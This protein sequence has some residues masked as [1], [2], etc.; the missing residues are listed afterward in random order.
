MQFFLNVIVRAK[1]QPLFRLVWNIDSLT[2]FKKL[3]LHYCLFESCEADPQL[4]V[5]ESYLYDSNV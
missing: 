2:D 4:F 5:S 3:A 1:M